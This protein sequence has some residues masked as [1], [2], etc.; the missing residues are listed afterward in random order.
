[1]KI[2]AMVES[3]RVGLEAGLEAAKAVGADGVQIYAVK[4]EMHPDHLNS[5]GRAALKRRL[6]GLGLELAALCGD[7]GHGFQDPAANPKLL[8]DSRKVLD[9]AMDLGAN[10]VTTHVGVVPADKKVKRYT[11]IAR[12]CEELGRYGERIG[13][14]FAIETGPEPGTV[15]AALLD[16]IAMPRGIG[17]NFDPANLVMVVRDNVVEAV[18]ALGKYIVHTH[19]K[20]GKNLQ[21]V[22]DVEVLYGLKPAPPGKKVSWGDTMKEL[23]LGEGD[24]NF[25]TYLSA[26]GGVGFDGYLTIEREVG[27]DPRKDIEQAVRFLK[28]KL[29]PAG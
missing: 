27:Q 7:F 1:M 14:T 6:A 19:A 22:E 26:L 12:A 18:K 4:G 28:E 13:A 8:D 29:R 24:V 3:F 10:V 21:P 11:I 20:D 23:P 17:V 2:G 9:L 25:D 5:S 16:D 15:L